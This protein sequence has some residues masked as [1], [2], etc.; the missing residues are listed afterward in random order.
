[1]RDTNIRV[2]N[3]ADVRTTLEYG[4]GHMSDGSS[5]QRV[6]VL[7]RLSAL[8]ILAALIL[9][10]TVLRSRQHV[11]LHDSTRLSIR[12]NWQSDMPPRKASPASDHGAL[13]VA[14]PVVLLRS[15]LLQPV[16]AR[17]PQADAPTPPPLDNAPDRFRGPPSVLS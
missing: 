6:A 5:S 7:V 13:H 17:V 15:P 12:L 9:V 1:M 10:P 3:C 14:V 8:A 2:S 11:D 16:L 4:I